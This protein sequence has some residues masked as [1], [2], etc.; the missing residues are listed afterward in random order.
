MLPS[1]P[2]FIFDVIYNPQSV[3]LTVAAAGVPGDYNGNGVVDAA[4]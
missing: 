1:V 4:D 3:V 2:G